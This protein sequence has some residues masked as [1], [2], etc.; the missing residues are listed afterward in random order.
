MSTF[1]EDFITE[2][3]LTGLY[4]LASVGASSFLNIDLAILEKEAGRSIDIDG[5]IGLAGMAAE[6]PEEEAFVE[7][8]WSA[9]ESRED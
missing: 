7:A 6:T 1:N 5:L 4:K 3:I 9:L 8:C 2:D